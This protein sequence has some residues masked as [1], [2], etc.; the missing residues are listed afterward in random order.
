MECTAAAARSS[1]GEDARRVAGRRGCMRH[2]PRRRSILVAGTT[3]M[4]SL[5]TPAELSAL[6]AFDTPTVCNALEL[7]VP[8]ARARGFTHRPALCG[9]PALKPIV[10]YARTARIRAK[11]AP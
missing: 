3:P 6:A 9:F 10:G 2:C 7:I 8:E 4:P 11:S 1:R 5:P